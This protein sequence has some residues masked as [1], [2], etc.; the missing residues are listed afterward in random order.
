MSFVILLSIYSCST[1]SLY[2]LVKTTDD[3]VQF[4]DDE[5]EKTL[6]KNKNA[7]E[8]IKWI[9]SNRAITIVPKGQNIFPAHIAI[10]QE[11]VT[12]TGF[13]T[14]GLLENLPK[15]NVSVK[16]T[17]H[18]KND[19]SDVVV[20]KSFVLDVSLKQKPSLY[21]H[22]DSII[23]FTACVQSTLLFEYSLV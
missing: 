14:N 9:L 22:A 13:K 19:P 16:L 3:V 2:Y 5:N 6:F 15:I 12:L 8:A 20:D 21:D 11:D 7:S 1:P 18:F 10:P 17:G 23:I 4:F